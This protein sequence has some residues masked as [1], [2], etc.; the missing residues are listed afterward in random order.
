MYQETQGEGSSA[1]KILRS[2]LGN[3]IYLEMPEKICRG[4]Q[5]CS[6]GQDRTPILFAVF[7][8]SVYVIRK[9]GPTYCKI[10]NISTSCEYVSMCETGGQGSAHP[11]LVI[12]DGLNVYAVDTT[13]SNNDMLADWRSIKLPKNAL[14][15][16]IKPSYCSYI[17]GFLVVNDL[18]TDGI[19]KSL[20]YP[21]ET[22]KDASV[23][24]T[25]TETETTLGEE[26]TTTTVVTTVSVVDGEDQTDYDI[27]MTSKY[28]GYGWVTYNEWSPDALTCLIGT[29]SHIWCFG[30]K[31]YQT[32]YYNNDINFPFESADTGAAAIGIRAPASAAVLGPMVF[33]LGASDI[34]Q[35]GI[36]VGQS[37]SVVKISNP[38][39][40]RDISNM[41]Y[42]E[43]AIGQCWNENG[44]D[45][46]A[47]TFL[48]DKQTLVFDVTEKLWH[49]RSTRALKMNTYGSW[50]PQFAHLAYNKLIFGTLT[51]KYLIY[52]DKENFKEYDGRPIIRL[53]ESGFTISDYNPVIIE[54]FQLIANNGFI[55]DTT[56]NPSIMLRVKRDGGS[57]S[58][59][60]QR[61]LGK[62]GQYDYQSNFDRLGMGRIWSF[63][64]SYTENT[65]LILING[66]VMASIINR[67]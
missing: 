21:F 45:F 31:S 11:H 12:V 26:I 17:K 60:S 9:D 61:K 28:D 5:V 6:F 20:Q 35:N 4:I 64:I 10:G 51:D 47:I 40:E 2:I 67:F 63:E 39:I 58:N 41:T 29:G 57:Y 49:N 1:E 22:S 13:L 44:H 56:L 27:F 37:T 14:D 52:L 55:K 36:Y 59:V 62:I 24:Q 15:Q 30:P 43:D 33:W 25:S 54:R 50:E 48:T 42:P 19:Y 34:G 32:W 53:R 7:G 65:D 8:Y 38:D 16:I 18:Q 46:Y 66:K 23:T 3:S